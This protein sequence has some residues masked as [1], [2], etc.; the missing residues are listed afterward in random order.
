MKVF[1]SFVVSV[2]LASPFVFAN[3]ELVGTWDFE[4]Y[5]CGPNTNHPDMDFYDP[6]PDP[7]SLEDY[8]KY[9]SLT[10]T[11]DGKIVWVTD[12]P[13]VKGVCNV[14]YEGPYTIKEGSGKPWI[15]PKVEYTMEA[16][17][18]DVH[19]MKSKHHYSDEGIEIV[20]GFI[21]EKFE[22]GSGEGGI[23][24]RHGFLLDN[25]SLYISFGWSRFSTFS[26]KRGGSIYDL[27]KKQ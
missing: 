25:D 18:L 9:S 15:L 20:Q 6:D 23:K 5:V 4:K 8:Q 1:L 22:E 27:H 16:Y 21:S 13:R 19:C 10:Y 26:C 7:S 14:T 3:E 17:E 2:I 24:G 12:A 11:A